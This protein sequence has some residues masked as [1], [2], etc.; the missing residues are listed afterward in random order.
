MFQKII[1]H[2]TTNLWLRIIITLIIDYN[3][4]CNLC[5]KT[6][7]M[8]FAIIIFCKQICLF[9]EKVKRKLVHTND[10]FI[11]RFFSVQIR[12]NIEANENHLMKK[13]LK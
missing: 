5:C 7:S 4:C 3:D 1:S 2:L 6:S 12:L 13:L 8:V 11:L 10:E 9:S